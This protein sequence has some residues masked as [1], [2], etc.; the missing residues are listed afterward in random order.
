M[1]EKGPRSNK[2]GI[3]M[4]SLSPQ[5]SMSKSLYRKVYSLLQPCK[6]KIFT[7]NDIN[8]FLLDISSFPS[9]VGLLL[10]TKLK[11]SLTLQDFDP[12]STLYAF[13]LISKDFVSS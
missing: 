11:L 3:Q 4:S 6:V 5:F 12:N 10:R 9:K 1:Q 2:Q 8:L 13:C 7:F